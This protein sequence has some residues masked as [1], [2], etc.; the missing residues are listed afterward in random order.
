MENMVEG[1]WPLLVP[2][3]GDALL[4]VDVQRDFCPGGSLA[5]AGGDHVAVRVQALAP[6]FSTVVTS[7]D[8][9]PEGHVSFLEQG[10]PW[11]IH[12][13]Q[14]TPGWEHPEGFMLKSDYEVRKGTDPDR[15]TASAWT[16]GLE[17]FLRQRGATRVVV[18][19][20]ALDVCVRATVLDACGAGWPVALLADVTVA[21]DPSAGAATVAELELAGVSI[22][23]STS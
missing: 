4:V 20:I 19:G 3:R 23:R 9:H 11:P 5:V 21:V 1:E 6:L 18:T 2:E 13:V 10:G 17:E 14:G 7:R 15:D 16:A 12:C 22:F 8:S